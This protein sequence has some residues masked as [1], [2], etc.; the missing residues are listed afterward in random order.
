MNKKINLILTILIGLGLLLFGLSPMT[1]YTPYV[2]LVLL[3]ILFTSTF[4]FREKKII[5]SLFYI[6]LVLSVLYMIIPF[7]IININ[8]A[9][10]VKLFFVGDEKV[11]ILPIV[12]ADLEYLDKRP[13]EVY[14]V[15]DVIIR[16]APHYVV[17]IRN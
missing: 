12:N 9:E 5:S 7:K 10:D 13:L 11:K 4:K 16:I 15:G 17:L 3:I 1:P 8:N 6:M 2:L 14:P